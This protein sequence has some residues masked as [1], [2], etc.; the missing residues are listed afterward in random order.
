LG[1]K[2]GEAAELKGEVSRMISRSL[3]LKPV[4]K[5]SKYNSLPGWSEKLREIF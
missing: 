1:E 2:K 4:I 5:W 3:L